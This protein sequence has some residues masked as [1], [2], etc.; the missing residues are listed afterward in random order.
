VTKP[1]RVLGYCRRSTSKQAI[2]IAEQEHQLRTAADVLGWELEL[3]NEDVASGKNTDDRHVLAQALAD[4]AAGRADALA[5][6]KLE[7]LARDVEDFAGLLKTSER[8]GWAVICLDLGVDTSTTT[9]RLLAHVTAAFAEAERRRIGERTREGMARIKATT[10]KHMGRPRSVSDAA[11]ARIRDLRAEGLS[12]A[13]I[14]AQLDAEGVP[15]PTAARQWYAATV[16]RIH[17]AEL[18]VR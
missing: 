4:L 10:G 7:R 17:A 11:V 12:F 1:L 13:R 6:A 15:T 16:S 3:R 18:A 14:A 5:G 2:S 8:Q 9:G